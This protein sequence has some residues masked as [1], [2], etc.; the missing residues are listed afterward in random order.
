M[1]RSKKIVDPVTLDDISDPKMSNTPK[2][3]KPVKKPK[4]TGLIQKTKLNDK[5]KTMLQ[6]HAQHHTK[7]HME[8]MI[9]LTENHKIS[10]KKA[11][12]LAMEDVGK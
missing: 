3:T 12:T 10:F 9:H 6:E 4:H 2:E 1:P 8:R 5:N 11:H 7:K